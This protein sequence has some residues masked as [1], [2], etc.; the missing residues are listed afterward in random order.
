MLKYASFVDFIKKTARYN[1][2][3][4][5]D[6]LTS[7]KFDQLIKKIN[8]GRKLLAIQFYFCSLFFI[9]SSVG[10]AQSDTVPAISISAN[11]DLMSRYIWRGQDYGH[12]PSIQPCLSATWKDFTLG[13][14]GV[15]SITGAGSQE[16]DFYLEKSIGHFTFSVSD[17]W[18]FDDSTKADFFNYHRES[19]THLL[20]AQ[21]LLSGGKKL[22]FNL[23]GSYL[24]YG[25][26]PSKSIY[27]ELQYLHSYGSTD[28]QVFAGFQA[29]GEYYGQNAKFV[30]LGC[31]VI[32]SIEVTDRWILPLSLSLIIN[33]SNESAYL[34]AGITL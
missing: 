22:P 17:Y 15:Y 29:K 26:D 10:F 7:K 30:N 5:G 28:M 27:L 11:V 32:K 31:T 12:S 9:G 13:T 18:S 16:T 4:S 3:S 25:A 34:V 14:W 20:E 33:P 6:T 8:M 23:L 21:V 2:T 19:T 24:F 1:E